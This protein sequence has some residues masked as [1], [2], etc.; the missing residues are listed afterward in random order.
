MNVSA[1]F[2]GFRSAA[3]ASRYRHISKKRIIG[4]IKRGELRADRSPTGRY[5]IAFVDMDYWQDRRAYWKS[6]R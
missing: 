4:A 1:S 3:A 6:E 5:L 2:D